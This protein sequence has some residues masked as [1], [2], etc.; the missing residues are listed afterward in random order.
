MELAHMDPEARKAIVPMLREAMDKR[1]SATLTDDWKSMMKDFL[2]AAAKEFKKEVDRHKLGFQVSYT[3]NGGTM[4]LTLSRRSDAVPDKNEITDPVLNATIYW[5]TNLWFHP[6][7]AHMQYDTLSGKRG[8]SKVSQPS[9]NDLPKQTAAALG[10]GLA[11]AQ[12][13]LLGTWG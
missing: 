3:V 11:W 2:T 1:A 9:A 13:E 4:W 8:M 12:A 7:G 10:R 5:S 6:M